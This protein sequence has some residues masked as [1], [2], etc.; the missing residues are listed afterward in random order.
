MNR[1][2][3][4]LTRLRGLASSWG[5]QMLLLLEFHHFYTSCPWSKVSRPWRAPLSPGEL[6]FSVPCVSSPCATC[7]FRALHVFLISCTLLPCPAHIILKDAF[8]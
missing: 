5:R 4:V 1:P 6:T 8:R 7:I 3:L 2:R